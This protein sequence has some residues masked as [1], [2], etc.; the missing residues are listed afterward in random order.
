MSRID[1]FLA[2]LFGDDPSTLR[3]AVGLILLQVLIGSLVGIPFVYILILLAEH[4]PL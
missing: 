1:S 3:F 4:N 2:H